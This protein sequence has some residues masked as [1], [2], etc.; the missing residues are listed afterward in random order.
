M[1]IAQDEI[2]HAG[3]THNSWNNILE[4]RVRCN[5]EAPLPF[6]HVPSITHAKSRTEFWQSDNLSIGNLN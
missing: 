5:D 4:T 6:T 2:E 3:L 1:I